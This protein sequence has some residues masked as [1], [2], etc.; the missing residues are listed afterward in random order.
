V[1]GGALHHHQGLLF[2]PN[3]DGEGE[4]EGEGEGG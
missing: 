3:Y 2:V 1:R 4:G